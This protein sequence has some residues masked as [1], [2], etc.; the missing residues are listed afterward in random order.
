VGITEPAEEMFGKLMSVSDALMFRYF[1]LVTRVSREEIEGLRRMHPMEAKKGLARTVTAQYHGREAAARAE[2]AFSRLFQAREV[3]ETV[4]EV[5]LPGA[6]VPGDGS[7]GGT[8]G[9]WPLWRV[10]KDAGLVPSGSEARRMIQQGAVEVDRRRMSDA[11]FGL[12]PGRTY[13]IQVGKRRFK[14]VTLAG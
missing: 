3:P 11:N 5:T 6:G 2:A 4:E 9:D 13:L 7:P 12:T 1:E 10:L 14:R 8:P